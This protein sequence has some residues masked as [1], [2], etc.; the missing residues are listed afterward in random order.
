[1]RNR[2]N[3]AGKYREELE[4]ANDTVLHSGCQWQREWRGVTYGYSHSRVGEAGPDERGGG[5]PP[6]GASG[7]RP[8]R[9]DGGG[10]PQAGGEERRVKSLHN[11]NEM[12]QIWKI[13]PAPL[14]NQD[15][16]HDIP[17]DDHGGRRLE[18]R[19]R[20]LGISDRV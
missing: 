20:H 2:E 7:K 4:G 1:M 18:A 13:L 11:S 17:G 16:E 8:G 14:P 9:E 19:K 10:G 3:R 15:S 12:E 5:A 6:T